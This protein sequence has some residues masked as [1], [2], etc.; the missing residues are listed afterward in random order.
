MDRAATVPSIGFRDEFK[1]ASFV[2]GEF[3]V[4]GFSTRAALALQYWRVFFLG[5][6]LMC[7]R[8][9]FIV[10]VVGYLRSD[11]E[12]CAVAVV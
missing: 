12:A 1:F 10:E 9:E 5:K 7:R 6:I 11:N 8:R 2:G 3:L 4:D